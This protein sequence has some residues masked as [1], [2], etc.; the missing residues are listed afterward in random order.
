MERRLYIYQQPDWPHLHYRIEDLAVHLADVRHRQGLLLGKASELGFALRQE[1]AL[2]ALTEE[3]VKTSEI[4]GE[5]LNADLVRSSVARRLG[6]DAGGLDHDDRNVEGAVDMMLD[7][8]QR[9]DQ[10][11]TRERLFGWQAALFPTGYSGMRRI[12]VGEWRQDTTGPMQVISG[13]IGRERVHFEAPDATR[14]DR[15]VEAFLDWFNSPADT[16]PVIK[17]GLAHL[18]FV[19]IHPFEDG[20]GRVARAIAE[21]LLARADSASQRFYSVSSQ[22]RKERRDYYRT[23]ERTQKGTTDVT[24]WLDWFLYC[25]GAAID[26]SEAALAAIATKESFWKG[27]DGVAVNERQRAM[28]NRLLDGFEG[29]LTTKKWAQIA[30]CSHDTALRDINELI[31]HGLLVRS[32][33]GGRST[34]Y[35]LVTARYDAET[36]ND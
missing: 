4:E 14:I 23:L 9:Y 6:L 26:R 7:A 32:E 25:V 19:T 33:A 31:A 12:A 30:K 13:P 36:P 15:E 28:L 34:S 21:M 10:P 11:L 27:I 1:A 17:A 35:D 16:D 8:T 24:R 20:N 2:A 3:V 5:T 18:W 22:I 29:K